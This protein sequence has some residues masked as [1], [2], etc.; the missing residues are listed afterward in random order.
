MAFLVLP[1]SLNIQYML[2]IILVTTQNILILNVLSI[3]R[4][5]KNILLYFK[6][7]YKA[8]SSR[9]FLFVV[10]VSEHFRAGSEAISIYIYKMYHFENTG[11]VAEG[12]KEEQ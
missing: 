11:T 9:D 6:V 2:L 8:T 3:S 12:I 5:W 1:Y 7:K 10:A 4:G